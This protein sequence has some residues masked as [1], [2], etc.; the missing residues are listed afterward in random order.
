MKLNLDYEKEARDN[1]KDLLSM[2]GPYPEV[3]KLMK[4]LVK[5]ETEHAASMEKLVAEMEKKAK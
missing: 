5:E 1:Y 2:V 3:E 4:R